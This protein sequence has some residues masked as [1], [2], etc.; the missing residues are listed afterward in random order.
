MQEQMNRYRQSLVDPDTFS[1]TW[2]FVPGRGAFEKSQLT[3]ISDAEKAA[4][5]GRVHGVTITDNPGGNPAISVE[6]LG[7]EIA[8]LGIEPLVHF[9]C[10]DKNRNQ[11]EAL[12]HGMARTPIRNL[13]V[14]TGDYTYSGFKSRAKPV[15]DLDAT[16]L[17]ELVTALNE[18]LEVPTF[19]G[20]T[21]LAAT[22]FFAGAVVSPFKVTEAEV[23]TQ[24][25]KLA[26]KLRAGAKFIATQLGYDARKFHEVLMMMK[27]LGFGDIPV[28][29]NVYVVSRP[30][31]RLMNQNGLPGCVVTDKLLAEIT[32]EAQAPDKG[33]SRRLERAAKM[34]AMM[35]GMGFAGVHIGGHGLKYEDVESILDQSEELLPGWRDLVA[36]FDYPQSDGWYYFEKNPET[37]LNTETPVDRRSGR[38]FHVYPGYRI[39]RLIHNLMFEKKGILFRPMRSLARAVDG[40]FIEHLFGRLEQVAKVCTNECMHCGDCALFDTAFVCPMSQCPKS[41]RNGPCGGSVNGWCEVY[42]EEKKCIYV[43]AYNRL[44][45]FAEEESLSTG[46]IPPLD[47]DLRFTSS[48]LN[49]YMGRDHT[50]KQ[51]GIVPP[52][53]RSEE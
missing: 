11:L 33:K 20:T 30:A 27:R 48:W 24:Y 23:V 49:F 8:R 39:F 10:K 32:E 37:G 26:K 36:E 9:S 13:L 15:F 50:A 7:A 42:P 19:K 12:L 3:A 41:Q 43:R 17:L 4:A 31:A 5:G 22:D 34:V 45:H 35:R 21:T 51:L 14:M 16:H 52:K 18:G 2:E 1:V 53:P 40:S 29:G 38:R 25:Y 28:I 46:Q 44:K 6:M 47:Y